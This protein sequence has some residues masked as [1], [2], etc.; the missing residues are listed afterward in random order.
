MAGTATRRHVPATK[1]ALDSG[2]TKRIHRLVVRAVNNAYGAENALRC[3]VRD[4][5][6]EMLAA[7]ASLPAIRHAI[8][9]CVVSHPNPLPDKRS[10]MTGESRT[11]ILL[12]RMLAWTNDV[13]A[14]GIAL[15]R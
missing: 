2:T 1:A 4:G 14:P 5:A 9:Q 3:A 7:G 11:S 10:L 6:G 13:T 15:T 12:A 8:A